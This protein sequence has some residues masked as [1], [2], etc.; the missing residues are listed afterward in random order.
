M[1]VMPGP[2]SCS[3]TPWTLNPSQVMSSAGSL[4][5]SPEPVE[6]VKET[7]DLIRPLAAE[8]EI[9][10]Q[11]LPGAGPAWTVKADRQRLKQVLLNLVSNAAKYNRHGGELP[12][13]VPAP[14]GS[15]APS[16]S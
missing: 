5:L 8:R 1:V 13:A 6:V 4:S 14:A 10:V 15:G 7:V 16:R 3:G 11:S 12:A 2:F 9:T